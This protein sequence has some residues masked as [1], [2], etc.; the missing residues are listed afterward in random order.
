MFK[1]Y[2]FMLI[3][4]LFRTNIVDFLMRVEKESKGYY[5]IS[6]RQADVPINF[7]ILNMSTNLPYMKFRTG[8]SF[9]LELQAIF[10]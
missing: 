9:T 3:I 6:S 5:Q 10:P 8:K 4:Q 2:L 7:N 1:F